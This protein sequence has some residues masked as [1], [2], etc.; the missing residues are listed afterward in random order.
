MSQIRELST[1]T[2]PEF[3]NE[4]YDLASDGHVWLEWR[5]RSFLGQLRSLGLPLD[6]AWHGLDVGCGHGIV[7]SQL[8]TATKWTTDGADLKREALER[9]DG[10]RGQNLLYDIHDRLPEFE[11]HYDFAVVFDVI[12][13]LESPEAFLRSVEFHVKPGGWIFVNVPAIDR[14]QSDF[15]H[16]VGH[17]RRYGRRDLRAAVQ[18]A[19]LEVRD[20]RYWGFSMLP[21]LVLRWLRSSGSGTRR[22][23]IERGI[24][25]PAAWM[26]RWIERIMMLETGVVGRVP[27]GTSLLLAAV[28]PDRR[29]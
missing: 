6:A 24:Q 27:L 12:E 7:R 10:R 28:R 15:D 21:Y 4:W 20:L 8:E 22:A 9:N 1:T 26:L 17:L 23:V 18:G 19:G 2:G 29:S 14:L 13:H 5:F 11:A 3:P 16:A 25:P